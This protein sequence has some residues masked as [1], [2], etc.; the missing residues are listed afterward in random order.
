VCELNFTS[1]AAGEKRRREISAAARIDIRKRGRESAEVF[2]RL[3]GQKKERREKKRRG[4]KNR[5]ASLSGRVRGIG[6]RLPY[7]GY[8]RRKIVRTF[9]VTRVSRGFKR[10][11]RLTLSPEQ[12]KL[13]AAPARGG[14]ARS[15]RGGVGRGLYSE[16][17]TEILAIMH[18]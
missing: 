11:S 10:L 6:E 7:R 8:R 12:F 2:H 18:N 4:R 5:S 15:L 13:L 17:E 14:S 9:K 16:V 3:Y 1:D